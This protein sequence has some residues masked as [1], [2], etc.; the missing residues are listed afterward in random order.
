M[1]P[2]TP[3]ENKDI[4]AE[5]IAKIEGL[6]QAYSAQREYYESPSFNET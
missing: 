5:A 3:D 1:A 6:V 2:P 4:P